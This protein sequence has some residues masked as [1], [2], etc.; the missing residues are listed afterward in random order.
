MDSH[1][2]STGY[3]SHGV[4]NN[5]RV[6]RNILDYDSACSHRNIIANS[7][8]TNDDGTHAHRHVITNRTLLIAIPH[9]I[10]T[11]VD[12]EVFPDSMGADNGAISM[13]NN[14]ARPYTIAGQG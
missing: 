4:S 5:K 2:P 11:L 8:T 1:P 14:K 10:D 3:N 12:V 7:N 6:I 9:D 13:L